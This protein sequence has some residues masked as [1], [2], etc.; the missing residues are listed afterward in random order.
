MVKWQLF[1]KNPNSVLLKSVEQNLHSFLCIVVLFIAIL[2]I[3]SLFFFPTSVFL[4]AEG[5]SF[6]NYRKYHEILSLILNP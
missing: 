4:I 3:L 1:W 6:S 2:Q 5:Y